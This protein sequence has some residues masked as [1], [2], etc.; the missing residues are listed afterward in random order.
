[1]EV[2]AILKAHAVNL[3]KIV[4]DLRLLASGV[5]EGKE[6]ELPDRQVGSSIMPGKVNP[7]IPEYVISSAHH[8]YA[9]DQLITSLAAQGCLDLN[10]YLP[11]IG[12]AMLNSLKLL[13]SMNQSIHSQMLDGLKVN[14]EQARK[15]LFRSPAVTTALSP[16]IGYHKSAELAR[17]MKETGKDI[18][19]ANDK[20]KIIGKTKLSKLMQPDQLLQKGFT[21]NDIREIL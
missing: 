2:H 10:A 11:E 12:C 1:V 19:T 3:E 17:V 5:S 7:V 8:I 13:I 21:M 15:K 18:F 14:E 20:L 9:N 4:S 6:I 16:L